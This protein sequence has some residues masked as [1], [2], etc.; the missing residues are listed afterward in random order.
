M[1]VFVPITGLT[2]LIHTLLL[3]MSPEQVRG[4]IGVLS[5]PISF[6]LLIVDALISLFS[7]SSANRKGSSYN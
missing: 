6:A 2:A 5:I 7:F 3:F 1:S 4:G